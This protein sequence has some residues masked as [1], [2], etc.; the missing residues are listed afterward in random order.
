[1][2]VGY[3]LDFGDPNRFGPMQAN[4]GNHLSVYGNAP[5]KKSCWWPM[6]LGSSFS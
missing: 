6:G 5:F 2:A 4:I 3:H 1:M